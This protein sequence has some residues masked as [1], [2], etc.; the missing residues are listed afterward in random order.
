M[1]PKKSPLEKF[2]DAVI[3]EIV[4]ATYQNVSHREIAVALSLMANGLFDL[5]SIE[6][7]KAEYDVKPLKRKKRK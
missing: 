1:K 7:L 5:P 4:D 6:Q 3:L 2:R